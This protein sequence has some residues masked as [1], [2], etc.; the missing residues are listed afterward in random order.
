M[1]DEDAAQLDDADVLAAVRSLIL[2][3]ERFRQ[4]EASRIGLGIS[5]IIALGHLYYDGELTPSDLSSRLGLSSGTMTALLDRLEEAGHA[6]RSPNPQDRRSQLISLSDSGRVTMS[7]VYSHFAEAAGPTLAALDQRMR[8]R[9]VTLSSAVT[10]DID[11]YLARSA[12]AD[13][14]DAG[15]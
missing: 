10:A 1:P 4:H 5:E 3:V 14:T 11:E 12:E 15:D 13:A 6:S 8:L 9:F 2:T 7:E